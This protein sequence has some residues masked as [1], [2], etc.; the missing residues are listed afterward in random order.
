M[1][2][3]LCTSTSFDQPAIMPPSPQKMNSAAADLPAADTTKSALVLPT[4]P[5]GSKVTPP[6][7]GGRLTTSALPAGCGTPLPSYSVD[8]SEWLLATQTGAVGRNT[9]PHGF[10]RWVSTVALPLALS[11]TSVLAANA[12]AGLTVNDADIMKVLVPP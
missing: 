5:V 9:I 1:T 11:A 10:T 6:L 2:M 4:I 7:E 8:V 3:A 12:V